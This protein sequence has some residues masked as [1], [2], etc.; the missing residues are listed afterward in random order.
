MDDCPS[1][2][3]YYRVHFS[4]STAD[5]LFFSHF[6]KIFNLPC[7]VCIH[8]Y[9]FHQRIISFPLYFILSAVYP[10]WWYQP[11]SAGTELAITGSISWIHLL[12]FTVTHCF[13]S[14]LVDLGF[15]YCS[16]LSLLALCVRVCVYL[17][18]YCVFF[19]K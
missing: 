10:V 11:Q 18:T 4:L 17:S 8:L 1:A 6:F 9:L 13:V 3:A 5:C 16:S 15:L 7:I 2:F 14:C 19:F 12:S